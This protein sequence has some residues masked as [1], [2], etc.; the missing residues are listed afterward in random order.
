[1]SL[2]DVLCVLYPWR[3]PTETRSL[4]G[5]AGKFTW[6][7]PL[8]EEIN[9][10]T[11]FSYFTKTPKSKKPS[12]PVCGETAEKGKNHSPKE[13]AQ[14]FTPINGQKAN[15]KER[16]SAGRS[17]KSDDPQVELYDIVWAKLEGHPWWPSLVCD[18]PT[19]NVFQQKDECHV[20]FF[21]EPPS[22]AW[23]KRR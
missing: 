16:K 7:D 6:I 14:G 2:H 12:S 17:N 22:R 18:H 20:Q 3:W 10:A 21:G 8:I 15:I 4:Q 13:G 5:N 1:M 11:L 19:Q 9:M 23:V